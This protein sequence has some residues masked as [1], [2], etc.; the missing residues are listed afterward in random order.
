MNRMRC[1]VQYP[2]RRS[3]RGTP[4]LKELSNDGVDHLIPVVRY[5][6]AEDLLECLITCMIP[7][8]HIL[9]LHPW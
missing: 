6:S 4:L 5:G 7:I 8:A 3:L 1:I 2:L 9:P